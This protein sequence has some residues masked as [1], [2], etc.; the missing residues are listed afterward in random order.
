MKQIREFENWTKEHGGG[1]C[2]AACMTWLSRID[3][4]G[5]LYAMELKPDECDELQA[6]CEK[7]TASFAW[8]LSALLSPDSTFDAATHVTIDVHAITK[9][10]THDFLYV[11]VAS[12]TAG[13]AMAIYKSLN[14]IL[15][16]NPGEGFFHIPGNEASEL[17]DLIKTSNYFD[18]EMSSFK[19]GT[20][21][22]RP[23]HSPRFYGG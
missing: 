19:K 22:G 7:G 23:I 8:T 20:L 3:T 10:A 5:L 17:I 9:L 14:G 1:V 6:S 15:F 16:F 2:D 12:K 13:H 18:P 11:V 4:R 21:R